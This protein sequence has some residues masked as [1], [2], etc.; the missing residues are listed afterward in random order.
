VLQADQATAV[1]L[2]AMKGLALP[3]P[4]GFA[5]HLEQ[6]LNELVALA[7]QLTTADQAYQTAALDY[8]QAVGFDAPDAKAIQPKATLLP[9]SQTMVA[10]IIQALGSLHDGLALAARAA[11]ANDSS[12]FGDAKNIVAKAVAAAQDADKQYTQ[13]K[14]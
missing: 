6:S 8:G 5:D 12:L 7:K 4:V 2:Q 1:G 14:G 9:L 11:A 10:A 13:S 3:D